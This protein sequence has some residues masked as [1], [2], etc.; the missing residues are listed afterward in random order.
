VVFGKR[1][2]RHPCWRV[3]FLKKPP[4]MAALPGATL[5]LHSRLPDRLY[6]A[7]VSEEGIRFASIQR[8]SWCIRSI[9]F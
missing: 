6:A 2:R 8:T 7:V 1:E 3:R 9:A 5:W 4:G